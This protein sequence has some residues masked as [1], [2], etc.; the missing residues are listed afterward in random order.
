MTTTSSGQAHTEA[1]RSADHRFAVDE[2]AAVIARPI[3]AG[4]FVNLGIG[5]PTRI[6]DHLPADS[7]TV[8]HTENGMLNMG[9]KTEGDAIDPDLTNAGKVPVTELPGGGVF[10]LI[11]FRGSGESILLLALWIGCGWLLRG[12]MV[13]A[14]AASAEAMPARGWMLFSGV[15]GMLAGMALIVAPFASI[16]ALTLTV[17]VVAI[18]LGAMEVFHAIRVRIEVGHVATSAAG[19]P[20]SFRS[21][22]RPQH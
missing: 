17:G 14:T 18:V 8:L 13:T 4:A 20:S 16:A 19:R 15:V 10:P 11:C 2:P 1:P 9:P 22:P 7:G 3:P 21:Q 6:A 12:I 5:Q